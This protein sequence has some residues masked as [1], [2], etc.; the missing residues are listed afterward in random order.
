MSEKE[1]LQP[2]KD[3]D[4]S[5]NDSS[6]A[7]PIYECKFCPMVYNNVQILERH[8]RKIHWSEY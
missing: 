5:E 7:P 8:L 4:Q 6:K 1:I 2:N 3:S